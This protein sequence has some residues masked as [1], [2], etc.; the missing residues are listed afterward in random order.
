MMIRDFEVL[1]LLDLR[2][3][4]HAGD[5]SRVLFP[6]SFFFL[7][8]SIGL[9]TTTSNTKRIVTVAPVF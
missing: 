7:T 1:I 2:I 4:Q 3:V 6:F 5:I 9:I 8:G